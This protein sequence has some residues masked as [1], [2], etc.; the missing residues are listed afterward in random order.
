[1][2]LQCCSR[3]SPIIIIHA[4][5][6][7]PCCWERP[8][9]FVYENIADPMSY[10]ETI[11]C[12]ENSLHPLLNVCRLPSKG[13][14]TQ[15]HRSCLCSL[16][17]PLLHVLQDIWIAKNQLRGKENVLL[18]NQIKLWQLSADISLMQIFH[19][20]FFKSAKQSRNEKLSLELTLHW[21]CRRYC[22]EN[23][24]RLNDSISMKVIMVRRLRSVNL[25]CLV[26]GL[27]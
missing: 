3:F 1:M 17:I 7:V 24:D 20:L 23:F 15:N 10:Q 16:K 9:L 4:I 27:L 26:L 11:N 18:W 22:C 19:S 13:S 2:S 21:S 12:T 6:T 5:T 14:I 25:T 8:S